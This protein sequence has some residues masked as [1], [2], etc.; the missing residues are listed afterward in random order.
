MENVPSPIEKPSTRENRGAR[1]CR[2]DDLFQESAEMQIVGEGSPHRINSKK[3]TDVQRLSKSSRRIKLRST[4]RSWDVISHA[5]SFLNRSGSRE[6]ERGGDESSSEESRVDHCGE[7]E[8]GEKSER[9]RQ[10]TL[11]RYPR[12]PRARGCDGDERL[13]TSWRVISTMWTSIP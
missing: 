9:R 1:E 12:L 10:R 6:R 7:D 5:G 2:D 13:L 4:I 8:V 11:Y 3:E